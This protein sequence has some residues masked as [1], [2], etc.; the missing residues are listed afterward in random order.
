[1]SEIMDIMDGYMKEELVEIDL[2]EAE[3]ETL[4]GKDRKN[5][6][7]RLARRKEAWPRCMVE[8]YRIAKIINV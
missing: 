6:K 5:A 1:M 7:R 3:I 4:A 8:Y 2:L